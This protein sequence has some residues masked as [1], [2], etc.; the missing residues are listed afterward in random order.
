MTSSLNFT[1]PSLQ[2]KARGFHWQAVPY[3]LWGSISKSIE[4]P[5]YNAGGNYSLNLEG[6]IDR[7]ASA[8]PEH[9]HEEWREGEGIE[10]ARGNQIF[11]VPI[12]TNDTIWRILFLILKKSFKII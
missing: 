11:G 10:P 12:I 2:A 8:R 9:E 3:A 1:S 7:Q 4:K 6:K 5:I